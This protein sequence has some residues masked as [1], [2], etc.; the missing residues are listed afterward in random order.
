M[1][2]KHQSMCR[3][4]Q[5]LRVPA[6]TLTSSELQETGE[7]QLRKYNTRPRQQTTR[8][9]M[10]SSQC[11]HNKWVGGN[12]SSCSPCFVTTSP[13]ATKKHKLTRTKKSS[14]QQNSSLMEELSLLMVR[15]FA[16]SGQISWLALVKLS[17]L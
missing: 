14:P 2:Q 6:P 1:L 3:E 11:S 4:R 8:K 9:V 5:L 13:A 17:W 15:L 7:L 16:G 10:S 12:N